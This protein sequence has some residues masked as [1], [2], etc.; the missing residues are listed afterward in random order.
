LPDFVVG[1]IG[2]KHISLLVHGWSFSKGKL[3]GDQLW[4][5]AGSDDG[6]VGRRVLLYRQFGCCRTV[7]TKAIRLPL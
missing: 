4:R 5:G 7:E 3:P 1:L 2:K 6:R